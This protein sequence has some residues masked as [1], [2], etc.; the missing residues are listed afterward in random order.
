MLTRV[1]LSKQTKLIFNPIF[2]PLLP[3]SYNDYLNPIRITEVGGKSWEINLFE[4][5]IFSF[6]SVLNERRLPLCLRGWHLCHP[7]CTP[8]NL[9]LIHLLLTVQLGTLIP[10]R[11]RY[12]INTVVRQD[13][14]HFWNLGEP[15]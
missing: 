1:E 11:Y 7:S 2:L 6:W 15:P 13:S 9:L 12:D 3:L 4:A 5:E 8:G 10:L 14:V